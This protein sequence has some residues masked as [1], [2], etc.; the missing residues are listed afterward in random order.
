[1]TKT[2][3]SSSTRWKYGEVV[4][5]LTWAQLNQMKDSKNAVPNNFKVSFTV[6]IPQNPPSKITDIKNAPW[7][8]CPRCVGASDET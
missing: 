1:M 3:S 4:Q 5:E 7:T 6:D 8:I 2:V